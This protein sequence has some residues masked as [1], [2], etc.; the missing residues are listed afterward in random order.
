M[1]ELEERFFSFLTKRVCTKRQAIEFLDKNKISE[2]DKNFLISEA[3]RAGL[4]DDVAYSGLFAN[5]HEGWGDAKIIYEL[6]C[7]GI[8]KEDIN[9]ALEDMPCEAERVK[10]LVEK[11]RYVSDGKKIF[12]RLIQRGFSVRSI[13]RVLKTQSETDY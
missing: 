5:G 6:S 1:E 11:W 13:N 7:R 3:E 8:S 4:I 2:A 12:R 10:E 9:I